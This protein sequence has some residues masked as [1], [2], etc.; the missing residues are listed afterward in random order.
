[1]VNTVGPTQLQNKRKG[2]ESISICAMQSHFVF[3]RSSSGIRIPL[4]IRSRSARKISYTT[5]GQR[6]LI[7]IAPGKTTSVA[8][9]NNPTIA[10]RNILSWNDL[11]NISRRLHK[12]DYV[13][14]RSLCGCGS[15]FLWAPRR[16]IAIQADLIALLHV[17][18]LSLR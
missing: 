7:K 1:M 3:D 2:K 9:M 11:S 16:R 8:P 4:A 18:S 10:E 5:R 12:L 13:S 6:P 15:V 17:L 14:S